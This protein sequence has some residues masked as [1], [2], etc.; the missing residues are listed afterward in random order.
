[1]R[2]ERVTRGD[3]GFTLVELLLVIVIIGILT[4]IAFPTL[5]KQSAK[6]KVAQLRATLRDAGTAEEALAVDNLPYAAPGPTGIAQL[7]SEGYNPTP[8]VTLTVVDDDMLANG[9]GFCLKATSDTLANTALYLTNAGS[10]AGH[11]STVACVA[12]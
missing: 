7:V 6:A 5:A 1:M 3:D 2:R 9:H 12:S 4:G 8:N 11:P 10:Q